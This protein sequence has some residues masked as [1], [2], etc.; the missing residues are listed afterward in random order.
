[1]SDFLDPILQK[2][3]KE[4]SR[5]RE[6]ALRDPVFRS[7]CHDYCDTHTALQNWRLSSSDTSQARIG[8]FSLILKELGAEIGEALKKEDC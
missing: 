2:Y 6:R 3:P 7:A 5:I 4:A 8:E 1:M